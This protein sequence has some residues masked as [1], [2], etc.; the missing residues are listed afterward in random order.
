MV[1]RFP[2]G[3]WNLYPGAHQVHHVNH[4]VYIP[5]SVCFA[6]DQLY[7]VVSRLDTGVAH[8]VAYG[9]QYMLLVPFDFPG[10]V[11]YLFD[12]AV[13]GFPIPAL[14]LFSSDIRVFV[15]EQ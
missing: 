3:E 4:I 5:E 11:I 13:A 7:L 8:L 10:K 9:I 2:I 15:L 1:L 14:E 12:T 6:N